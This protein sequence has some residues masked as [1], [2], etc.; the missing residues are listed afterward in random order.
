MTRRFVQT[1]IYGAHII[2]D[3]RLIPR[4]RG[5]W[6]GPGER[7]LITLH[8]KVIK[9]HFNQIARRNRGRYAWGWVKGGF[10]VRKRR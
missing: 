4:Y 6:I 10:N 3:K 1:G 5:H 8:K 2:S 9:D 7:S